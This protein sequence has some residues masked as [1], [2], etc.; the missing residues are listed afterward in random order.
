MY[1]TWGGLMWQCTRVVGRRMHS[2]CSLLA[3]LAYNIRRDVSENPGPDPDLTPALLA[4]V[5]ELDL[6]ML[7]QTAALLQQS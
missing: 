3:W 4:G 5:R 6:E 2:V 1:L 7:Q